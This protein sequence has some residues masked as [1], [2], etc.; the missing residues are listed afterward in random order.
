MLPHLLFVLDGFTP[1][2]A[3]ARVPGLEVL[4]RDSARLGVTVLCLVDQQNQEPSTIQGRLTVTPVSEGTQLSYKETASGGED[5]EFITPDAADPK[6]CETIARSLAPLKLVD[7]EADFNFDQDV[8][9][10]E[11]LNV[12]SLDTLRVAEL[13]KPRTAQ[14]LLHVPIGRQQHG[15]LANDLKEMASRGFGPHG[16]VVGATGS[17]K[18]ELL[19]TIVT[20]LALTHDPHTVNFVLVDFKAGA[21]FA[22]FAALPHVAGIITNLE[23]DPVLI[24]RMYASLLGEQ[25][26]R[27][28]MLSSA[29]NLAN[30]RQYQA[31][32]RKDP[33]MEPMP[34]LLIIVDEFAQL[35][36]THEEFL[37]LFTK[38][39]QVGRSLG[40]HMLL[41]TQRVDDGRIKTL[42]GHLRYRICLR[43]FKPEESAA[44]LGK[45][46]AYYLPPIPGSGYF[47]VDEDIYTPFKTALISTPYVPADQQPVDPT[48]LIREFTP[49][50]KL[51]S[52]QQQEDNSTTT[53]DEPPSEMQVVIERIKQAPAPA[54]GWSVHPVW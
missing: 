39:G 38:F 37:A 15:P 29:G 23:N 47:K 50:G 49:T 53:D 28:N 6:V 1:G 31:K 42:E 51:I 9:L 25:Q 52:C 18:S 46:D 26:R 40:M 13:W 16:L 7:T 48:T 33:A 24:S 22:D 8:R 12:P 32:W 14:E 43:T 17:G 36:A 44:V 2:G 10:L 54:E 35:I 5:R 45:P 21:A 19:R 41:A 34:Y 20:S 3:L 27:Q 30:I 11:L 4:L